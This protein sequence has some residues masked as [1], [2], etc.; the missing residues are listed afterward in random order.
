M[1]AE[2]SAPEINC[3]SG[4][5]LAVLAMVAEGIWVVLGELEV[6][7]VLDTFCRS[8]ALHGWHGG[9]L[10]ILDGEGG[11]KKMRLQMAHL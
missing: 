9:A 11:A 2:I 3:H 7:R 10:Y 8:V 6:V 5:R 1:S 4:A